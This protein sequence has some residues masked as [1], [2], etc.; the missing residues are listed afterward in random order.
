LKRRPLLLASAAVAAVLLLVVILAIVAARQRVA[1]H[2]VFRAAPAE[3]K[4][5][6]PATGGDPSAR[7]RQLE[8]G[9]RWHELTELLETIRKT[10]PDDYAQWQLGYLHARALIESNEP[11]DAAKH[12]APYLANGHPFRDLA[13]FHQAEIDDARGDYEAASRD[14][15]AL[16]FG[17]PSSPYRDQ[18]IDDEIEFLQSPQRLA[19]FEQR[20]HQR[21]RDVDA[22]LAAALLRAKDWNGALQKALGVLAGGTLDDAAER[23]ARVLDRPELLPRLGVPQRVLLG[24]AMLNHRHFDRAVAL[25]R[26]VGQ[27]DDVV[28]AIGRAY[29]GDEKFAQAQATYLRGAR[30]TK[31][32]PMRT[33]FLWHAARAAQLQGKDGLAEQLM[34]QAI[35]QPV[36][37]PAT[38]AA[39]TQRLRTR[40]KQRRFADAAADLAA[41]RKLFPKD[42]AVVEASLAYAVGMLGAGNAGACVVTLNAIPRNLLDKFEPYEVGYWRARALENS[43]PPA[44]FAAYLGVLRA[45]APTHFAYFAR[46]RLDTPAMQAKLRWELAARDAEVA[47][48][49]AANQWDAARKIQTDR[50]LLQPSAAALNKLAEI[51]RHVPAYAAILELKA[52]A[53]PK[54]P[55]PPG[56]SRAD[57]L[58]AMGLFDEAAD[59]VP[60]LWPLHP[61]SSGLTQSLALNLGNASKESIFAIEVLMNG[62]PNDTIPQLLPL[63]VRELLYPRYFFDF[64]AAD[65][66]SYDADA[67]LVLAIMREESRF[68][69]RAKSEAAA[70]GLLQFIITTA[71]EIGRDVG[72]VNVDEDDLYDPRVIIRLGAKYIS[73]LSKQL[74]G[75][76][77]QVA[78]AYNAGPH[79]VALWSRLAG[80][81]GDDF[82]L[83]A[84]SF[85]E[86][87]QY[88]RK[89]MNSYRRYA[90]IYGGAGPQG[91][92][93]AEP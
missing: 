18:A 48:Q 58:M 51:Y 14:R 81:P 83:T 47:K 69:P 24:T 5:P 9:G 93:R 59:A 16:I 77:Y 49:M 85:D 80:A 6:P 3:T 73:T 19:A 88:V 28:F 52:H 29:Y 22:H 4:P 64:I 32:V 62:V 74:G 72:L 75:D 89:V 1:R 7:F 8:A 90:E 71:R 55:L 56:A 10:R 53:F 44:S 13:L 17:Y 36:R 66:K 79:Q 12:L 34:T 41:V 37:T 11:A 67:T 63:V 78:A 61:M 21:R 43:N 15:E 38:S 84:V 50:V 82:F 60:R 46:Q 30:A 27:A 26:G 68:N 39:L 31:S 91:G 76:R 65:A 70:R 2:R 33:T 20:L 35:A 54:F 57:L 25:L 42:H 23:T 87:K 86:T 92:V 45:T 40:V